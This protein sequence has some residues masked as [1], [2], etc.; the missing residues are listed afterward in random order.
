MPRQPIGVR[1]ALS[2]RASPAPA[3]PPA[4]PPRPAPTGPMLG[5]LPFNPFR[6]PRIQPARPQEGETTF[7][8]FADLLCDLACPQIGRKVMPQGGQH[9]ARHHDTYQ[10]TGRQGPGAGSV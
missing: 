3:A 10:T 2:L 1:E 5:Y 7:R 9:A 4:L 6:A 8:E